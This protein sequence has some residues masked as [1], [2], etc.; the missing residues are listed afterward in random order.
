MGA[1]LESNLLLLT[2]ITKTL[3]KAELSCYYFF[4]RKSILMLLGF[5]FILDFSRC[6]FSGSAYFSP[7][8]LGVAL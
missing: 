7:L 8:R 4:E 1:Q 5:I 3:K 2:S 6:Q